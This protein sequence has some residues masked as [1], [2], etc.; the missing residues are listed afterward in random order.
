[1]YSTKESYNDLKSVVI[2]VCLNSVVFD[3]FLVTIMPQTIT[4]TCLSEHDQRVL[5]SIFD[6]LELTSAINGPQLINADTTI[7]LIDNDDEY[8]ITEDLQTSK[9]LEMEAVALAEQKK[10]A[11]ALQKFSEALQLTPNR[12]SIFNN[13][14]QALRLA[15]DRDNGKCGLHLGAA[16]E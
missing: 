12:A 9:E 14:A 6:P 7:A 1:M 13:R 15:G 4:K 10:L 16:L 5:E 3:L 2:T 11:E 8:A